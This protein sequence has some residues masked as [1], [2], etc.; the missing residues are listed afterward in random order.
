MPK[1]LTLD[2]EAT[3]ILRE[4]MLYVDPNEKRCKDCRGSI[5]HNIGC[6][7]ILVCYYA[8]QVNKKFQSHHTTMTPLFQVDPNGTCK[9]F[10]KKGKYEE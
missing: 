4:E 2:K 7:T 3:R 1:K 8:I 6:V 5:H 9:D 10:A